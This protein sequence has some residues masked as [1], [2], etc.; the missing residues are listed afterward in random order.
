MHRRSAAPFVD[1]RV[2]DGETLVVGKLRVRVLAHARP[3]RRLDVPGAARPRVHRRHAADRRHRPHRPADRRSGG[4]VRQPVRQA[5]AAATTTCWSIPRTTTRAAATRRSAPRRPAT[6]AC[7][8]ASARRLR[9]DDARPR[10]GDAA[11]PDRGAAHQLSGGKTVAQLIAE[12]AR[13]I[14]FMSMD[15]VAE[16]HRARRDRPRAAGRARA[17]RLPRRPHARRAQHPARPA[18]AARQQRA[19]RSRRRAS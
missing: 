9:R 15:E 19:A 10:P 17:G 6:R 14:A 18:R 3:Y 7:R 8:S 16:Q 2:D 12:A 13:Q 11:A 4:A 5:A 1:L